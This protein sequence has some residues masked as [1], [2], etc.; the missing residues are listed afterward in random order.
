MSENIH[1]GAKITT[2]GSTKEN[3]T[4]SWK[5]QIPIIDKKK[6]AN[7]LTCVQF[8]PENCIKVKNDKLD[9]IDLNYCKGCLIC[10]N[11]CPAKAITSK[12]E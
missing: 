7:C 4:G 6:C 12:E 11:E 10:K 9:Y 8:C 2:P 5:L 1:I 3:K